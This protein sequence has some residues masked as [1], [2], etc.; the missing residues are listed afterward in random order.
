MAGNPVAVDSG[1]RDQT[2]SLPE[3]AARRW[4]QAV[5]RSRLSGME[6][7]RS[8]RH[9]YLTRSFVRSARFLSSLNSFEAGATL[10]RPSPNVERRPGAQIGC[11]NAC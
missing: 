3:D 2:G 7:S 4:G 6:D 11:V 5:A 10:G 9:G 8:L 1:Q